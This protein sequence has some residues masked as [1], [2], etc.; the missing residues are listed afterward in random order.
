MRKG[1]MTR[2]IE[3]HGLDL[4]PAFQYRIKEERKLAAI[5]TVG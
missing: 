3:G 4:L 1:W 2:G 5:D